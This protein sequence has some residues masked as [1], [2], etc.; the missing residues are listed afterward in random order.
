MTPA[1]PLLSLN[2]RKR[3]C[4]LAPRYA[5]APLAVPLCPCLPTDF[6]SCSLCLAGSCGNFLHN[7]DYVVAMTDSMMNPG[8]CGKQ[9]AITF[10]GKTAVTQDAPQ[11]VS[12]VTLC[13]AD[14]LKKRTPALV[15]RMVRLISPPAFSNSSPT[16]EQERS[17]AHGSSPTGP[18]SSPLPVSLAVLKSSTRLFA[19]A[20][21]SLLMCRR[22]YAR[23]SVHPS[24]HHDH[25]ATA[26]DHFPSPASSPSSEHN[27]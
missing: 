25:H 7:N 17:M 22:A 26:R 19:S 13:V 8:Y 4:V 1:L 20:H 11:L 14:V 18:L 3:R 9:V 6:S 27:L 5:L 10:G 2:S 16:M 12:L 23:P 24:G 15:A 21:S